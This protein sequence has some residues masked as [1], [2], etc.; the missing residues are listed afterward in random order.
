M[1][2]T[3]YLRGEQW[4]PIPGYEGLYEISNLGRVKS[5]SRRCKNRYSYFDSKE[6]IVKPY[7]TGDKSKQYLTVKLCKDS[8]EKNYKLHRLIAEVFVTPDIKYKDIPLEELQ[9]HHINENKLDNRP[10]NLKW[11]TSLD[12]TKE[13]CS[14]NKRVSETL[15]NGKLSR[16]INQYTMDGEL[17]KTWPSI[18]E[19]R[20][21]L[22]YKNI[23]YCCSGKR[24]TSHNFIWRYS[25]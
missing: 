20:R 2:R 5:L 13:E 8:T 19:I 3:Y 12:H 23:S 6:R 24:N 16:K 10:K 25:D 22:G 1:I 14:H 18:A 7:K 21:Q 9:V 17:V 15:I 11:V 4:Q